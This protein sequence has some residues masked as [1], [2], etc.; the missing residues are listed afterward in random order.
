VQKVVQVFEILT[1]QEL[2][3]LGAATAGP[4]PAASAA[5]APK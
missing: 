1:E 3:A 4:A 2:A 5:S